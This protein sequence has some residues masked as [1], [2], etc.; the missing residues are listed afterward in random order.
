LYISHRYTSQE[1]ADLLGISKSSLLDKEKKG[2][3]PESRR[4]KRGKLDYRFYCEEDIPRYRDILNTPALLKK[5]RIQVFLNCQNATG[6][7]AVAANYI[8]HVSSLGIRCLAI[9]L[10]Q[11]GDLTAF[12]GQDPHK[13][14]STI[15]QVLLA[16]G[17]VNSVAIPINRYLH[18]VPGNLLLVPSSLELN[19]RTSSEFRLSLSLRRNIVDYDLIVIDV[20]SHPDI[21]VVNAIL[22]ADDLIIPLTNINSSEVLRHSLDL[23]NRVISEYAGATRKKIYIFRNKFRPNETSF[24]NLKRT[25]MNGTKFRILRNTVRYDSRFNASGKKFHTV[26]DEFPRSRV[27]RDIKELAEEI[28]F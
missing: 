12:L 4:E 27:T 25:K 11:K 16:D 9:D 1:F 19:S 23:I 14:H 13:L 21:F 10:D 15:G 8:R 17:A 5:R 26:V 18:L 28:L 3:L 22:A 24:N 20:N 7:S 6:K 2:V